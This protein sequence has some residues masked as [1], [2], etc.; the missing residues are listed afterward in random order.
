MHILTIAKLKAKLSALNE[1]RAGVFDVV[2][3]ANY[4]GATHDESGKLVSGALGGNFDFQNESA[5]HFINGLVCDDIESLKVAIEHFEKEQH[6]NR[7]LSLI[8]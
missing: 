4:K 2:F 5:S 1:L 6:I 8:A 3:N 7:A